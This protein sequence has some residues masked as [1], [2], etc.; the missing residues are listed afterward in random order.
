MPAEYHFVPLSDG[1]N[2]MD[3]YFLPSVIS[4][5]TNGTFACGKVVDPTHPTYSFFKIASAEDEEFRLEANIT[6]SKYNLERFRPYTPEFLAVVYLAYTID[7]IKHYVENVLKPGQQ[8]TPK[9]GFFAR[10]SSSKKEAVIYDWT[11]QMGVPT[12]YKATHNAFRKRKF[13]QILYMALELS[14][15]GYGNLQKG[16]TANELK[17]HVGIIFN[18]L[19]NNFRSNTVLKVGQADWDTF[20]M[21]RQISVFPE[22]AAGLHFLV[23]TGRLS[24][25]NYYLA[26]DIGGGSTDASFFKVEANN[27]F[28]YLA[29]KSVMVA[30]NDIGIQMS[31]GSLQLSE[32]RDRTIDLFN[33]SDTI[34]DARYHKAFSTVLKSINKHI[35]RMF[36]T[37]VY[38]RFRELDATRIYNNT[39]CYLYGGGAL[40]PIAQPNPNGLM[41]QVLI[42]DN[43]SKSLTA[44]M[45]YVNMRPIRQLQFS[46]NVYPEAWRD[47]MDFLI[48]PLGLSLAL[49]EDITTR[50]N[51]DFYNREDLYN[52]T[53]FFNVHTARWV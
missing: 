11:F 28:T 35:Y 33:G 6:H 48:V 46:E 27:T 15:A 17:K 36:N 24:P 7:K 45:T 8:A 47:K 38:F 29:S 2:G 16:Y 13:Q 34:E 51:E 31:D 50:L 20:L 19:L 52:P 9:K 14:K 44:E 12:E 53:G 30:A 21:Q 40:M 18:E 32:L 41:E 22:T 23:K 5:N 43:G 4:E 49:S 37:Q 3:A 10:F 39:T 26:L 1:E 25:D 42:H